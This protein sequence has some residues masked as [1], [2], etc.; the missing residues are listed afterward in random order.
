[1]WIIETVEH[2]KKFMSNQVYERNK[3]K[4]EYSKK[5]VSKAGECVRKKGE[6]IESALEII[7]NFRA[8]H[9]YPLMIIKNL[10]WKHAQKIKPDPIIVRRLK[11]LP[12]IIDKLQRETLDG[13]NKNSLDLKRLQDIGGCRVIVNDKRSLL[14]IDSYLNKSKTI[15]ETIKKRDYIQYPK[16]TGY[17]GIH[18]IY[19]SYNK[20]IDEHNWKG[21]FIE[22]QIRTKLQHVW[23][24]TVEIID[25][26]ENKDLKTNPFNADPKWIEFF[27]IMS[28]LFADEEGFIALD[29]KQKMDYKNSLLSLNIKLRAIDKL[30]SLRST[31]S[32]PH[33][34]SKANNYKLIILTIDSEKKKVSISYFSDYDE[35]TWQYNWLEKYEYKKNIVLVEM[36][37]LKNLSKAYPNYLIDTSEFISKFDNYTTSYYWSEKNKI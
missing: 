27:K 16:H 7:R 3:I 24:T 37:D 6:D 1:M 34:V 9:S 11:R 29:A 10:V 31:F 17:R 20:S 32:R 13:I 8:A 15:H 14:E 26:F 12:T 33:I 18:R 25:I 36:D 5:Q 2:E 19:K 28:D 23:A 30:K 22:V 4:L 21:F 35:A